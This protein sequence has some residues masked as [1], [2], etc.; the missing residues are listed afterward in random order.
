[1]NPYSL[2]WDTRFLKRSLIGPP[3]V[4]VRARRYGRKAK[5]EAEAKEETP[6]GFAF[7]IFIYHQNKL[8][9]P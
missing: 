1:M 5:A 4:D 9:L 7:R 8:P 6:K 3:E 2:Q